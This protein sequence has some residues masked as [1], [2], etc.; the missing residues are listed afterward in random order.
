MGTEYTFYDYMEEGRNLIHAWLQ[1]L[2]RPVKA[3]FNKWL[4]H[5]EGVGPGKWKRGLVDTLTDDCDGLFEIRVQ[6]SRINYRILGCHETGERTPT[7]LHGFIKAGAKVPKAQ[8]QM[9]LTRKENVR[10]DLDGSREL[11]DLS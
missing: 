11:H 3:K 1:E 7:L 9:A 8:C 2:P 10:G 6:R 5:L 4:L